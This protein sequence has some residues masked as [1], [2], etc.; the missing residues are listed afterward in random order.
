MTDH[1]EDA[2]SELPGVHVTG[3]QVVAV[4]MRYW[5]EV[6]GLTQPELGEILG[7]SKGNVSA[8]ERS[9]DPKN[10]VRRFNAEM[11]IAIARALT[12]P[13]AALFMPP[14]DDGIR[15][16]YVTDTIPGECA[17][18]FQLAVLAIGA[19]REDEDTPVARAYQDRY[20]QVYSRYFDQGRGDELLTFM[21]EL[22]VAEIRA[23]RL[24]RLRYQRSALA[25]LVDDVDQL[26]DAISS[27]SAER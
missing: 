15:R 14:P 10:G 27:R 5:R 13:V 6:A 11:I 23:R 12:L 18:M 4:N 2:Y 1:T 25:S 21:D 20:A 16:R 26:I 9:A 17:D 24:E 8:L 22:G 19:V 7:W 3:D